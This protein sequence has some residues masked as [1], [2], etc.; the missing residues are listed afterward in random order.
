MGTVGCQ[1]ICSKAPEIPQGLSWREDIWGNLGVSQIGA[2]GADPVHDHFRDIAAGH[3]CAH[4]HVFAVERI[5]DPVFK[6]VK[7]AAFVVE[8]GGGHADVLP[9]RVIRAAGS[10]I[11]K[12]AD[13]KFRRSIFGEIVQESLP[14]QTD[15]E[16]V[17]THHPFVAGDRPEM[18]DR[19]KAA[20]FSFSH[21]TG[22]P[23]R[24]CPPDA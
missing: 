8:P 2:G 1:G 4:D 15:L 3:F 16:A 5:V 14:V 13:Q 9:F 19:V 6:M 20:V 21:S 23:F 24:V 22:S 11:I 10:L 17:L 7:V 18:P 12:G